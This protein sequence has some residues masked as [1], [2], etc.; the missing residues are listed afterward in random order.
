MTGRRYLRIPR[1]LVMAAL[2]GA[3]M[4]LLVGCRLS[5]VVTVDVA[6][7][8]TGAVEVLVGFDE[9]AL[10]RLGDPATALAVEDLT[11]AGWQ[12][13]I[14][15]PGPAGAAADT[16]WVRARH[17]FAGSTELAA[18]LAEVGGPD[19][20]FRGTSLTVDEDLRSITTR[21]TGVVDLSEGLAPYTDAALDA[22]TGGE[23]FGGLVETIEAEQGMPVADLVEVRV[24][25]VLDGESRTLTPTLGDPAEQVVLT[26]EVTRPWWWVAPTVG[27]AVVV[28]ALVAGTWWGLR[29]R[30]SRRLG[31]APDVAPAP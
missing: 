1:T 7:D 28:V 16:T 5:V 3:A 26:R 10:A 6:G 23:P 12:L 29:R 9:A 19:G 2:L 30:A 27:G 24:T 21:L 11:D 8:G 25:W 20:P 17:T 4:T 14:P 15:A 13:E 18:T 31:D 22:T